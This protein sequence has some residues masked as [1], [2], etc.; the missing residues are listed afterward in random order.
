MRTTGVGNP[1]GGS[2]EAVH[3]RNGRQ[4][5]KKGK[6]AI[7]LSTNAEA[8]VFWQSAFYLLG[9]Y[10]CWPILIVAILNAESQSL[11]FWA[12]L[13]FIAPLQGFLNCLV[14]VR[15]RIMKWRRGQFKARKER[16]MKEA[17]RRE[18]KCAKTNKVP[19]P[20]KD[21]KSLAFVKA[22]DVS[23]NGRLEI[24]STTHGGTSRTDSVGDT[25]NDGSATPTFT[26]NDGNEKVLSASN[27]GILSA[28]QGQEQED[29][30][31]DPAQKY[32]SLV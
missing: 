13:S 1:V 8:A 22:D 27:S 20:S 26:G 11:N 23:A 19:D 4:Q 5:A 30:E 17:R 7:L 3:N 2:N 6:K 31:E 24:S 15:P 14:F 18:V 25:I 28:S 10:I 29:E 16:E 12:V 9:Y 32:P 21:D